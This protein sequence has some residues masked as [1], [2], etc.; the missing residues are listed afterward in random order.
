MRIAEGTQVDAQALSTWRSG[1]A[2]VRPRM[3]VRSRGRMVTNPPKPHLSRAQGSQ[4]DFSPRGEI[5]SLSP[6]V[7][8][9]L[10]ERLRLAYDALSADE[11]HVPD[12]FVELLERLDRATAEGSQS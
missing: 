1:A 5:P 9:Q 11:T 8:A 3:E 12:R 2:S 4:S 6:S 7:Q 10:G